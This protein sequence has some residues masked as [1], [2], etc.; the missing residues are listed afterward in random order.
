MQTITSPTV[1]LGT[2][3]A[4]LP[5]LFAMGTSLLGTRDEKTRIETWPM[6]ARPILLPL[7]HVAMS[8]GVALAMH[9]VDRLGMECTLALACHATGDW[10]S[11]PEEDAEANTAA[12]TNG[13]RV[14]SSYHLPSLLGQPEERIW[15]ITEADRSVT[16]LLFPSEY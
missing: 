4:N 11:V 2:L 16:T 7:G 15:I 10:G 9:T 12:L 14:L 8:Q 5:M 1:T 6:P 3:T 13:S